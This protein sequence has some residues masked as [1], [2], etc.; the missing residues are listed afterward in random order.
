MKILMVFI[1]INLLLT[2]IIIKSNEVVRM[3]IEIFLKLLSFRFIF[4]TF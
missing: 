2:D 3:N 4:H 1:K